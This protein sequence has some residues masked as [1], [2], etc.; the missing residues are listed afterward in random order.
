M[1]N[2]FIRTWVTKS[3][4]NDLAVGSAGRSFAETAVLNDFKI[5]GDI[6]TALA[7]VDIDN[8]SGSDLDNYGNGQ[9]VPRPQARPSNGTVTISQAS[10]VKV[11]T[12]VYQG[13]PAPPAGSQYVNVADGS[14]FPQQGSIYIGRGT[15]NLEGPI[16]YTAITPVGSY[17]Q[18]TLSTVTAK[19][20]NLGETVILAQGGNRVVQSG[21]IVQTQATLTSPATTFRTLAS[22]TLLD[23]EQQLS[24]VPVVAT[25]PGSTSNV[26]AA[27]V[28][29]FGNAPFPNATAT[30]P[31]GFTS[32]RDTMADD[33]YRDLIKKTAATKTKATTLAVENSAIDITSSD[34][35][36]TVTSAKFRQP[37]NRNEPGTLF[38]DNGA[39]YEP[40][41]SGQ[42]FESI[43]DD[44]NGGEKYL[45]LQYQDLTKAIVIST[46]QTPF[47][48]TGGMTLSVLVGGVLS[49]HQFADSDFATP[50]AADTF[51]VVNSI[52]ANSTL[53]FSARSFMND[54]FITLFAKD[55]VNEDIQVTAPISG[56]D[57]NQFLGFPTTL[58]YTLRLYKNEKLLIK[59]GVVP[60]VFSNLQ[61]AWSPSITSGMTLIVE[62][63][64]ISQTATVNDSDFIPY[65]YATVNANNS[66]LAW[67][68]VLN[69]KIA[70][71]TFADSGLGSLQVS[72]NKG[73]SN[74]ASIAITGGTLVASGL[75]FALGVS[76]D[77]KA[78][79]YALNRSTGQIELVTPATKGDVFT[80]GSTSTRAFLDSA[81][82]TGG[83]INLSV[84]PN[85]KIWLIVDGSAQAVTHGS[86]GGSTIT[87]SNPTTNIWRYTSS[88]ANA[89]VNVNVGDWV[90]VPENAGFSATNVGYW[91]VDATA[92]NYFD[93]RRSTSGVAESKTLGG[94]SDLFFAR[95]AGD[96]QQVLLPS[97]LQTISSLANSITSTLIGGFAAAVAGNT[98]RISTDTYDSNLGYLYMAGYNS[99]ASSLG[100]V[101]GTLSQSGVSHTAF[102]DSNPDETFIEFI[103]D[104]IATGDAT[105][106]YT[107]A[108]TNQNLATLGVNPNKVFK[109]LDP[110]NGLI[111]SNRGLKQRLEL[112]T[113]TSVTLR[114]SPKMD[115]IIQNDRYYVAS[116]YNFSYQDNLVSIFDKDTVNKTFNINM[117]RHGTVYASTGANSFNAYDTDLGPTSNFPASFGNNFV[118]ND[119]K[120]HFRA[121]TVL[122]PA[123][124]NNKMLVRAATYGPSGNQVQVG[125]FYP[126]AASTPM[127]SAI[128][129]DL[130]TSVQL[131]LSSG[132]LRTG[133]TWDAT[134]QFDVTNPIGNTWRYTYNT[135]GTAPNFLSASIVVGDVV[136]I[137][138]ASTFSAN[139]QGSYKITAIT[140]VYFEITKY[141]GTLETGRTLSS[142]SS[143]QFFPLSGDTALTTATYV[144]ANLASY[145]SLSQLESGAGNITTSTLDDSLGSEA[146]IGLADGENWV[147]VSNI[148]TVSVPVNYFSLKTP[149]AISGS[150]LV[151]EDFYLIPTDADQL[152]RYV[153]VFAVTGLSSLAQAGVCDNAGAVQFY[154][155]LFGS[156]GAVEVSGGTANSISG[157]VQDSGS[158]VSTSYTKFA[159]PKA[160]MR[161][162]VAGQWVKIQNG[163]QLTKDLGFSAGTEISFMGVNPSLG[164]AQISISN[165]NTGNLE[166][167]GWFQT[168]RYHDSDNTTQIRLEKQGKFIAAS[169]TGLG[170][171]PN[172]SK[173]MTVTNKQ[174]TSSVSTIT[175]SAA[176]NVPV[177]SFTTIEVSSDDSSFN[178]K[179]RAMASST[180]AFQYLQSGSPDV[181]SAAA[182]GTVL[183]RLYKGDRAVFSGVFTFGNAGE[184]LVVNTFGSSTIYFENPS[185]MVGDYILTGASDIHVISY[186]SVRPGDTF[187]LGTSLLDDSSVPVETRKGEYLVTGISSDTQIAISTP[188]LSKNSVTT[189]TL[190]ADFVNVT[191]IE[192]FPFT[193]YAKIANVAQ[194]PINVNYADIVVEGIDLFN[195]INSSGASSISAVSKLAFNTN[196]AVGADS[197]QHYGGLINAVGQVIRGQ[198]SDPI[199]Y[200]GV[201]AA[202]SYIEIDSALKKRIQV[203]IVIRNKT[204]T[205]FAVVRNRVQT[206]VASYI[207]SLGAGDPVVF[208]QIVSAAQSIAGVQAVSISSPTYNATNDQIISQPNEKP[209]VLSLSTDVIVSLAS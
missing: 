183:K 151:G 118:F 37:A 80:A 60:T 94:V 91:R 64:G 20:H 133:G 167:T 8:L 10:F 28:V 157:A 172:F 44:A 124:A 102:L 122:D 86:T 90:V 107:N 173:T 45:Q 164:T 88:V 160:A 105:T 197:Y 33:D 6:M 166:Q 71:A 104:S 178:G 52:N 50:N 1:L 96:M 36:Q 56:I 12:K 83:S 58:T 117:G 148:G 176:H 29:G 11:A 103:H 23:G 13:T 182:S 194:S 140:N 34:D 168:Q 76:E 16:A 120:V 154:S 22:V 97:G 181:V 184:F 66:L 78:S 145:I 141:G 142:A 192:E 49:Q 130:N 15:N 95:S 26:P 9:G 79:D 89:F 57:A 134:T 75:M 139:N 188:T 155:E 3:G 144:T 147:D 143:L 67:A 177:N 158:V 179:F 43:I 81:V 152:S 136:A 35:Q 7:S 21:S 85:P 123:G 110:Y 186:D 162:F 109:W 190:G 108:I 199:T 207:N 55:F 18:I 68:S 112:I 14:A 203:S 98:V 202:G 169:W 77:G 195:K 70:G 137:S 187:S 48:I 84:S 115:D 47:A 31:I 165:S 121:R 54:A 87:V 82:I 206:A 205:P 180:T 53:L 65:G 63:D 175:L 193:Q 72:S 153:N 111:S 69:T 40:I 101:A 126:N 73:A 125:F 208:S 163:V 204:G 191:V 100:F 161:G 174:R 25:T 113:G 41:F 185:A 59:D 159:I 128:T 24:D 196:V 32:G 46:L 156:S 127:S 129:N 198:A 116:G 171:A 27:A 92:A 119:F 2:T 61:S 146:F 131:Y 114:N 19:N 17:F 5:Q 150:Q 106:P 4:T 62:V 93:V 132:A 189:N 200:P 138:S 51:E 209:I 149:L 39:G 170:T 74:V 30:N 42:G 201:A 99:S 38:I 135:I